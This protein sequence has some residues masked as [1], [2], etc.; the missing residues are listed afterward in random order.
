MISVT[1]FE[2][3]NR[4]SE[5][6]ELM[7]YMQREPSEMPAAI[8]IR[9]P[10]GVGKSRLTDQ[11]IVKSARPSFAFCIVDPEI[12]GDPGSTRLHDGFFVQR[13]AERL[14]DMV[15]SAGAPWPTLM[16]FLQSRKIK[17]VKEMKA[18]D[19]V[20]DMPGPRSAYKIVVDYV[21]RIFSVGNFSPEML[22]LSDSGD[23][24][25]ITDQPQNVLPRFAPCLAVRLTIV[26]PHFGQFG[27]VT[28]ASKR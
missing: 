7:N 22:L 20:A 10:H 12:Q 2:F 21:S 6:A 19:L 23:A 28:G 27:S 26:P 18:S 3:I 17:T 25:R 13:C 11:M 4:G 5:L 8:F 1:D 14:T 9:S 16:A 15:A 24:V